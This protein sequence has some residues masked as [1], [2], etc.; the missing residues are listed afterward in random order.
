VEVVKD[1]HQSRKSSVARK[2][3]TAGLVNDPKIGFSF[4]FDGTSSSSFPDS[5]LFNIAHPT[6]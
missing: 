3:R 5:D 6:M 4:S 2:T 1:E